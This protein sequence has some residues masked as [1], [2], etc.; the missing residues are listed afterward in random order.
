SL[1]FILRAEDALRDVSSAARFGAGIPECP[2]LHS[3]VDKQSD[4][5][6]SPPSLS[7]ESVGE[8][9]KELQRITVSNAGSR[10]LGESQLAQQSMHATGGTDAV[11][12]DCNH[13]SHFE[14]ELE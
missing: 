1:A 3:Q 12:G 2:P 11:I 10:R 7:G 6:K 4:D 13:H 8:I 14:N 5:W 9:R